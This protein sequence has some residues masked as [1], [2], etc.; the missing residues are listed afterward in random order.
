MTDAAKTAPDWERIE[1][2]YRAGILSLREI[3]TKDGNVTEGAIRKRAKRDNWP[4]D[5]KAKIDAKAE[6]LVRKDAVRNAGTQKSALSTATEREVVEAGAAQIAE[7]RLNHRKDIRRGRELV[8]TL[9][10]ELEGQTSHQ[11]MLLEL[12]ELMRRE[13]DNGVD[14][15]NDTYHK[16][17]GSAGRIDGIKK[18]SDALKNLIG[19][20]RE[21]YGLDLPEK[22]VGDLKDLSDVEIEQRIRELESRT[23]P[24]T[25]G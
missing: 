6:D 19:L 16:I 22:P 4:R 3:A 10:G 18:L 15:L 2:D 12:G 20:E 5:L 7:V 21:A 1:A 8:I 25:A 11:D 24:A 9:L 13:N 23:R 14:R 17:I